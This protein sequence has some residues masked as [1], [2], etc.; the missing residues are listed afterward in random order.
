MPVTNINV[1]NVTFILQ[2]STKI[3]CLMIDKRIKSVPHIQ[4]LCG[5]LSKACYYYYNDCKFY[6]KYHLILENLKIIIY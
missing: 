5:A 3:L 1:N 6:N 2:S 4:F